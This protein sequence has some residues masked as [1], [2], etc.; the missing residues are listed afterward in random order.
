MNNND[1]KEHKKSADNTSAWFYY[2]YDEKNMLARCKTCSR[3][4]KVFGGSTSGLHTHLKTQHNINLLKRKES[5]TISNS[6]KNDIT[7]PKTSQITDFFNTKNDCFDE[8]LSRMTAL[9]G[10]PFRVF[11]T[12]IELRKSLIARGFKNI[13]KSVNIIRRTVIN[14]SNSVR[15]SLKKELTELKL[16]GTKFSLTFDEWTSIRNRRYLNINIHSEKKIWN[17]GLTRVSGS[18]PATKC[19]EV[20]NCKL[21]EHGLSLKEDIVCITTDGATVMKKVGKLIDANQQLC[22]AHGIHLGVISVLYQQNQEQKKQNILDLETCDSNFEESDNEENNNTIFESTLFGYE[23]DNNNEDEILTYQG[24]L[25]IIKKIRKVVKIF[26]RSP[27]KNSVLQKYILTEMKKELMLMLDSK[28]RWNTLLL[29]MER[30]LKLKNPIMKA[31]IDLNLQ[32]NFSDSEFDLI[33]KTVSVLLPIKLAVEALCRKNSN[34]LTANATINFML[35]SLKDQDTPLSEELYSALKIRIEE[36]HSELENILRYLHN[37]NDFKK[38][39]EKEQKKLTR[40]NLIKFVLNFHKN[41]YEKQTQPYPEEFVEDDVDVNIGK[42]LSL[43]KKLQLAINKK[44]AT[45]NNTKVIQKID[46]SKTVRRETEL[47]E[48]EGL[49]G[50]YLEEV[51]RSLLTI[52]PTSV[53]AERAFSTAGNLCTKIRS[54]LNDSSIDA[55]CFLQSH[56][57]NMQLIN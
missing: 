10:L 18:M 31:L 21:E 16:N 40:S 52:P 32:I 1:F 53:V 46:L 34:L 7:K 50:K 22:Y 25:P 13:P 43:E 45:N 8:V 6:P 5:E 48:D 33:S 38:E 24:L 57:K 54:R 2:L 3:I 29:M 15:N 35:Q 20:V 39:N 44:I 36:R 23:E 28:T 55:L 14:Y 56:F 42:E 19:V 9:D 11:C 49:R 17:I 27:T 26:K 41:I 4:I 47:L 12:S 37:Y 51:Y 30:F